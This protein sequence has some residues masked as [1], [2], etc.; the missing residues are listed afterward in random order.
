MTDQ[1]LPPPPP[2]PERRR[3]A[4]LRVMVD[5]MLASIRVATH[6]ELWTPEE[7]AQYESELS[8]IMTRVRAQAVHR[9]G[10]PTPRAGDG[11]S[12]AA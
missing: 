12:G 3:N 11:S 4:A 5:E 10:S 1:E 8:S 6:R 7:R 2:G 9:D